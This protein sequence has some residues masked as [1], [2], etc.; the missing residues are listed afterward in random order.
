[1]AAFDDTGTPA[2]SNMNFNSYNFDMGI[3]DWA[4]STF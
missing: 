1:M 3:L 2:N 4:K